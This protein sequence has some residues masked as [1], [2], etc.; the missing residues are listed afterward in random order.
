MIPLQ[1]ILN[2]L[3]DARETAKGYQAK[4]PAHE[5]QA[6]SLSLTE[7]EEGRVLLYCHAGCSAEVIMSAIGLRMRDLF[8]RS[9]QKGGGRGDHRSRGSGANTRTGRGTPPASGGAD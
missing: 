1:R 6:P 4:C 7:G 8:Q 2:L 3:E 9:D 5:D